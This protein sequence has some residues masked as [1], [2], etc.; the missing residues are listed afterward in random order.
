MNPPDHE[1]TAETDIVI[2]KLEPREALKEVIIYNPLKN[3][4]RTNATMGRVA[5][6][7]GIIIEENDKAKFLNDKCKSEIKGHKLDEP[8]TADEGMAIA[9]I[10]AT[11]LNQ[12]QVNQ[13]VKLF[14]ES[15]ISTEEVIAMHKSYKIP[16]SRLEDD[17]LPVRGKGARI[18]DSKGNSY[19]DLDSNYSATNLGNA[20]P[21]I[22]RGLYNQANLLIS[23][24]E[25][26][27]QVARTRFLRE[28]Q[29]MMP[30]GLTHF[31]W[32]NSGG[33]A[34][35]KSIKIAKAYTGH[36]GVVAFENG[37]HGRTHGAVAVTYNKNYREPFGLDK[38]P[39]V[40][41][42]PFGNL[43]AVE[44]YLSS[45]E[46]KSVILELV[47]GEEA[48]INPATEDFAHGL[49]EL[50]DKYDA[51]VIA[52]EVQTGF[53]RVA[54]DDDQWFASHVYGISPDIMTIGKSFGGGYPVTAVVTKKQISDKMHPGMDGSTFGGNPMAMVAALIATRQMKTL[55]LPGLAAKHSKEF[56][57]GLK[58]IKSSILK[59]FRTAGLMIGIDFDSRENMIKVQ[60]GMKKYGAHS[61]LSTKATMRWMPP[62][63]IESDEVE[64]VIE[65]F[66]KSLKEAE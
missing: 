43:D 6:V 48:G 15:E 23:Q 42:A 65:A 44:K 46:A 49:R 32:Q 2:E 10:L 24:K 55:G 35:D 33:E 4:E 41:F 40:H 19:I 53:G 52:D 20:N 50:C 62:L 54:E 13:A 45:G 38:E 25:D 26:R 3:P 63:V 8:M 61:S 9:D 28:I 18:W 64:E 12:N 21:E 17:L 56:A 29:G 22:A 39:W 36:T 57:S 66:R 1:I 59:G 47:Q 30:D 34:V 27:I 60:E 5:E 16:V 58:Q 14:Y 31:Y 11:E 51:L 7:I 37:F